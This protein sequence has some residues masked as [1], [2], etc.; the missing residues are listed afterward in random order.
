MR[1]S[2][3]R[4]V[5][6]VLVKAAG[7]IC[8]P[9]AALGGGFSVQVCREHSGLLGMEPSTERTS[10]QGDLSCPEQG[11]MMSVTLE[12]VGGISDG[13]ETFV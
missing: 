4:T 13:G 11:Y 1:K 10:E 2:S 7:E 5:P 12:L 3:V 9:W 8:V 6:S